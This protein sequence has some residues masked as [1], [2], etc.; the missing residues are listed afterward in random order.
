MSVWPWLVLRPALPCQIRVS[1]ALRLAEHFDTSRRTLPSPTPIT[2]LALI[3]YAP[4]TV[5]ALAWAWLT[6]GRFAWSLDPS[7]LSAPYALRLVLS[8][9][10]G[11]VLALV[12][13]AMTPRLVERAKWARALHTELKA[14]VS[15]LSSTE[16]SLLA[17]ASGLAEELFFRGA[18]QPVLG[19]VL[20]SLIFGALHVGPKG[21]FLAWAGWA[22]VMGLAFGSIFEL[23]GVLWGPVLAHVWI[24]QRNMTFI[25]RH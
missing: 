16:V 11:L 20:T 25:R 23:T 4:L 9:A 22:F 15:P 18:M 5:V 7:W 3:V 10:L 6:G 2:R 24:N 17:V 21:V 19:L 12:A 8:L 13:V 14:I 1:L